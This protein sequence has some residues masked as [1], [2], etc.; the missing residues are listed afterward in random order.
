MRVARA[1]DEDGLLGRAGLGEGVD[2]VAVIA[3]EILRGVLVD[4]PV[5]ADAQIHEIE[6]PRAAR[7]GEHTVD[8]SFE[9]VVVSGERSQRYRTI[10]AAAGP[11]GNGEH[12]DIGA[13]RHTRGTDQ[14]PDDHARDRRAVRSLGSGL[15]G[16]AV[17]KF[18]RDRLLAGRRPLAER[19][20]ILVDPGIDH[21][22]GL[23]GARRGHL[24]VYLG[25]SPPGGL[26]PDPAQPPLI[27]HEAAE[28][29]RPDAPASRTRAGTVAAPAAAG[30]KQRRRGQQQDGKP[31]RRHCPSRPGNSRTGNYFVT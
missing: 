19:R 16:R 13:P 27:G 31:N 20:V 6:R 4:D 26:R 3:A 22:D 12:R 10:G 28:E 25:D 9:I 29:R 17:E 18:F 30:R 23:A 15:V 14:P 24:A 1:P 5:E 7:P 11:E 2:G 8:H 21:A